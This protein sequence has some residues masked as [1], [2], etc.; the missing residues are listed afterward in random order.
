[1]TKYI[2]EKYYVCSNLT[3]LTLTLI[4][5]SFSESM[6]TGWGH[7]APFNDVFVVFASPKAKPKQFLAWVVLYSN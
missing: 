2:I 7:R 1:M 5:S 6:D 4:N 3:G